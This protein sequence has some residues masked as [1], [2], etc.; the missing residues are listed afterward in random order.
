MP[1]EH[2][3]FFFLIRTE[4]RLTTGPCGKTSEGREF[5]QKDKEEKRPQM[6]EPISLKTLGSGGGRTK[7]PQEQTFSKRVQLSQNQ[8]DLYTFLRGYRGCISNQN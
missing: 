4:Q 6:G 2:L 1:L 5:G 3:C 7:T 8:T